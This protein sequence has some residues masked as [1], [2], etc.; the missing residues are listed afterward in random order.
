[1]GENNEGISEALKIAMDTVTD[2]RQEKEQVKGQDD[3]GM[4]DESIL[5]SQR[6]AQDTTMVG[7]KSIAKAAPQRNYLGTSKVIKLPYIINTQEYK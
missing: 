2:A 6:S 1:M 3:E 4:G 7:K 5:Q